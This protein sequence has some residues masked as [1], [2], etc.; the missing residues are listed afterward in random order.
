MSKF[1]YAFQSLL[2]S[3]YKKGNVVF[4]NDGGSLISPV[5]LLTCVLPSMSN[6]RTLDRLEIEL[7]YSI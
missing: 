7:A 3:A 2:G 5:E 4:T 1:D 6:N